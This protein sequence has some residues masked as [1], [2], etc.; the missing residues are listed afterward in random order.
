MSLEAL[1]NRW[2][3]QTDSLP[4]GV[5]R[6]FHDVFVL[7]SEEKTTLTYGAD[8]GTDGSPCLVNTVGTMLR[9]TR[10]KAGRGLPSQHFGDIVHLFDSINRE[11]QVSGVND[12]PSHVSP[13]AAEVF[14][15]N[16]APL[17]EKPEVT[18]ETP[19]Y[20][21]PTDEDM[22]KALVSLFTDEPV[23]HAVVSEDIEATL[24]DSP[25]S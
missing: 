16:F 11:L 15:R 18:E 6:V 21:E 20:V 8:Y 5:Q 14:L 22:A 2:K 12:H 3:D 25:F 1:L 7:A 4:W 19:D 24:G 10:G 23:A 17:K 13:L 9:A